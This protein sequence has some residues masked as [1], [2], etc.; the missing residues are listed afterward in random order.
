MSNKSNIKTNGLPLDM[1]VNVDIRVSNSRGQITQRIQKH[2]K[3][4]Y[5]M[6]EGIIKFL[7]GEFNNTS[8]NIDNIG[9]NAEYA[10][11]YIPSYIGFGDIGV[12]YGEGATFKVEY[13]NN[14]APQFMD[15]HLLRELFKANYVGDVQ[16]NSRLALQRST[17]GETPFADTHSL[18]ISSIVNYAGD[19]FGFFRVN[20]ERVDNMHTDGADPSED[21]YIITELGLFSGNVDDYDSKL[22]AR[23]LLDPETPL[24]IS[25]DSTVVV[26][27]TL[28]VY[29]INDAKIRPVG[30]INDYEYYTQ[31]SSQDNSIWE[32]I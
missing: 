25:K 27:W 1:T 6:L 3:A 12:T 18:V 16:C 24:V 10:H 13:D 14:M 9:S 30:V 28:G 23:L 19:R 22:L 5:N 17:G 2:N 15:D 7:R 29:S 4:T 20:G 11:C 8:L 21:V 32:T 26:N 31:T